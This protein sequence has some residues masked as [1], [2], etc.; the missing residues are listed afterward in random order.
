[1]S[2]LHGLFSQGALSTSSKKARK[3]YEKADELYKERDFYTAISLLEASVKEDPKFFEA[4]VRMGGLY[5]AIAKED[6]TYAKFQ[7]YVKYVPNP[8]ASIL[9]RLAFMSFDRGAYDKSDKFLAQ[10]LA[11]V[12]EKASSREIELLANSLAFAK[13]QLSNSTEDI[14]IDYLPQPVNRFKL[15]YLPSVTVDNASIFYT[16]RDEVQGDEDIVVSH[17]KGGKWMP[18]VSISPKINTPLNEGACS[19]SADGRTMIFT[20]CDRRNSYGSCD[21]YITKKVGET[22]S[23]PKN[24]GK[25]VNSMYWESQPSLSADGKTLFFSSNR[26]G[27]YG[28]RDIWVSKNIGGKWT[29]PSNLGKSVNTRKDETTPFIHPNG[30]SLYFSANGYIGMGGYDLFLSNLQDSVWTPP[31][32]L[33]YPI[34]THK[35]EVAIVVSADGSMAYYAK[36]EQKNFEILD[37]KIVRTFL[38]SSLQSPK[39]SYVI[40]KVTDAKSNKPLSAEIEVVDLKNNNVIYQSKADSMDGTYY[41]VLPIGLELAAYIKKKGYLYSDFH[42][43]TEVNSVIAP[44]TITIVLFPVETGKSLVL[45]NIYFEVDSYDIND[46]SLSEIQNVYQLM[47]ENP[48]IIVE[49]SGHTDSTGSLSYNKKLSDHRAKA[50]YQKLI[51][52]GVNSNRLS[53]KGY[54]DTQPLLSDTSESAMQSNRRIEF[55]ILKLGD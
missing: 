25:P 52:M 12:P 41:M 43:Q 4:Y 37:S 35:D 5:Q 40:G 7:L 36:E 2:F 11:K 27:G 39:A 51:S 28:G 18:A 49:I 42:F 50:V 8:V 1:M 48:R 38:P 54:A 46:K 16:K 47:N 30:A 15:Q 55:R 31:Q 19:V 21:L 3:L 10:F 32:N 34:N 33:G 44:D 20:S 6:S 26:T 13:Q 23:K 29:K 22:W 45:K 24:L 17:F 14:V 9:E 53:Y